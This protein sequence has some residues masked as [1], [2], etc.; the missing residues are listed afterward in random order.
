M[1]AAM[2]LDS[3]PFTS[4]RAN[5]SNVFDKLISNEKAA[6]AINRKNKEEV[7]V[8]K[9]ETQKAM[10]AAYRLKADVYDEGDQSVTVSLNAMDIVE[11]AESLEAAVQAVVD[12]LKVYAADYMERLPLFVNAPN[13]R[14]HLPYIMRVILA[15]DDTEIKGFIDINHAA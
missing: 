5:L 11:N 2:L 3:M 15:D 14:D 12:E 13:R 9:R 10:L 7:L 4:A 8:I 6:V 1:K